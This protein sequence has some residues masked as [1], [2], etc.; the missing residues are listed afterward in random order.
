MPGLLGLPRDYILAQ[1]GAWRSGVRRAAPP[2]CM[3]E[4]ARRLSPEDLTAMAAWLSS[5][6][7]PHGAAA[8]DSVPGALPLH[9]GSGVQ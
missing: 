4:I 6:P 1:F 2:D 7:V 3:G 8:A 9:C 5:Q